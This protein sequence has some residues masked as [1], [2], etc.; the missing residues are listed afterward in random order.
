LG[1]LKETPGGRHMGKKVLWG[2]GNHTF[3]PKQTKGGE[4]VERENRSRL[5]TG[6]PVA[7]DEGGGGVPRKKNG[8]GTQ[9]FGG[10]GKKIGRN[11][12][13]LT[14]KPGEVPLHCERRKSF[15]DPVGGKGEQYEKYHWLELSPLG[16]KDGPVKKKGGF[17]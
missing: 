7:D 14:S 3:T 10:I 13:F 8:K 16:E 4:R 1:V 6:E 12:A 5:K 17:R 2:G 11:G 9:N 15:R